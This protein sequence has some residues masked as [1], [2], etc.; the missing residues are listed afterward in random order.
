[1]HAIS[2]EAAA[3]ELVSALA[4]EDDQANALA[5]SLTWREADDASILKA[6]LTIR[7]PR[8]MSTELA[9]RLDTYLQGQARAA[10]VVQAKTLPTLVHRPGGCSLSLW[11][12]DITQ[13]AIDAIVNACNADL[14]GCFRPFHACID[15]AIHAA[16]GPSLRADCARLMQLQG[17][18]EATGKAKIT[19]AHHLPSQFV[20]H[21]VGPIVTGQPSASQRRDLASCYRACLSLA[22]K[23]DGVDSVAFCGIS[24]GVFGFPREPAAD[25]ALDT[26]NDWLHDNPGRLSQVVFDVFS[27]ADHQVYEAALNHRGWTS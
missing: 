18:R 25:I 10:Q 15:N 5:K 21:T 7:P 1:V 20:L 19:P 26:V 14:L 13:L 22:D 27:D 4:L 23:Q 16:A 12:G 17:S 8:P 24:T 9:R 2:L 11:Q 3:A 6:L